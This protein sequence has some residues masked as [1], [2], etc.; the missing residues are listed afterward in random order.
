MFATKFILQALKLHIFDMKHVHSE[1]NISVKFHDLLWTTE[2][3][4]H[5]TVLRFRSQVW[6]KRKNERGRWHLQNGV[7]FVSR[8]SDVGFC[9]HTGIQW[10]THVNWWIK[11]NFLAVFAVVF[12]FQ[13]EKAQR[14]NVRGRKFKWPIGYRISIMTILSCSHLC[15]IKDQ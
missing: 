2:N 12:Y 3:D 13:N 10:L 4:E 8:A 6:P 7:R 1:I 5:K 11:S 14:V 9:M 15:V